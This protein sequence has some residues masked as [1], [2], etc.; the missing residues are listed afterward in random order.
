VRGFTVGAVFALLVALF[1]VVAPP[2]DAADAEVSREVWSGSR[3]VDLLVGS[4]SV[5]GGSRWVRLLLP[6]GWSRDST[7][8]WPTLWL[9]HGGYEDHRN[10]VGQSTGLVERTADW[11]AIVVMPD[12]SWCSAYSDWYNGG[13]G[14]SPKWETYLTA[15][16][17][18]L[19]ER[20]YHAS[21][22]RAIAGNS[23]GGGGAYGLATR[24]SG[25]YRAAASFSGALDPL[26]TSALSPHITPQTADHDTPG[27]GCGTETGDVWG[28]PV[29][30]RDIWER[31]DPLLHAEHLRGMALFLSS[32]T[33]PNDFV[34]DGVRRETAAM[35][36]T[37]SRLGIP[38][39][40]RSYP[41]AHNWDNWRRALA[42]ALPLLG[43]AIGA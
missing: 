4:P 9:L 30:H 17:P 8:R 10:W 41:Y 25:M 22:V 31:H 20:H 42:D 37:L 14:G 3:M 24:H 38:Y 6:N 16:L 26:H 33:A 18:E 28:D 36:D 2:A 15:E 21:Q 35:A 19:L 11:R 27:Q 1:G 40:E 23:M 7:E 43:A 12:T 34:E 29:A 5:D 39:T 32:G 13:N